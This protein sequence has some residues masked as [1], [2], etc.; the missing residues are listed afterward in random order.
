[1]ARRP[2]QDVDWAGLF[3]EWRGSG[4]T[5]P[6]FCRLHDIPLH[7]FRRRLY[8]PD[9]SERAV[10]PVALGREKLALR[11]ERGRRQD[12]GHPAQHDDDVQKPW[13]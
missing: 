6:E 13:H 9:A 10:K 5:Q 8:H 12:R 4:L 11:R 7:N 3:R 2:S 1:M